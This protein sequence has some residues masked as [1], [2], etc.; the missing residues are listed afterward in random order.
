MKTLSTIFLIAAAL[1]TTTLNAAHHPFSVKKQTIHLGWNAFYCY[2]S[3]EVLIKM[4]FDFDRFAAQVPCA[5]GRYPHLED[6]TLERELESRTNNG[7]RCTLTIE[8]KFACHF[9]G[10]P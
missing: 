7:Y 2:E 3:E 8:A 1:H 5:V 9:A 6:I 10:R 4:L